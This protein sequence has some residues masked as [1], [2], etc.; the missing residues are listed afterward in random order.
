MGRGICWQRIPIFYPPCGQ[1]RPTFLLS[2]NHVP[3]EASFT[4][5][6]Y[7]SPPYHEFAACFLG[8]ARRRGAIILFGRRPL[9]ASLLRGRGGGALMKKGLPGPSKGVGPPK[10]LIKKVTF[11]SQLPL[12]KPQKR[13][14]IKLSCILH[15]SWTK[16][17]WTSISLSVSNRFE[18]QAL[19]LCVFVHNWYLEQYFLCHFQPR[20]KTYSHL[21]HHL[22]YERHIVVGC[23]AELQLQIKLEDTKDYFYFIFQNN[24]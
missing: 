4:A 20:C 17:F 14:L 9:E 18:H 24:K 5:V 16:P 2:S 8:M 12:P 7:P 22:C 23:F 21:F 19:G 15:F 13:Y 11:L 3:P 6:P 1:V 10:A